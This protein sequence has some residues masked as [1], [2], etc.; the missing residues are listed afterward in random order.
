MLLADYHHKLW[1]GICDYVI[2]FYIYQIILQDSIENKPRKVKM[3]AIVSV[4]V[5]IALYKYVRVMEFASSAFDNDVW[6]S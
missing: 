1:L 6:K 5:Q 3:I 4:D 2:S